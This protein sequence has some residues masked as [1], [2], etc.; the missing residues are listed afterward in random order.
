LNLEVGRSILLLKLRDNGRLEGIGLGGAGPA[1]LDLAVA[2]DEEL[3]K[4]PLHALEAQDAGLLL[5]EPVVEGRGVV[6]VDIDLAHDGEA[7]AIVDQA[8]VLD[9]VVGSGLL[10]AELVAREAKEYN[11]VVVLV[12]ELLVELL[13]SFVLRGETALGGGVDDEDDLALVVLEVNLLVA[14]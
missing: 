12:A 8:K 7:D 9:V 4:V 2:A 3:F 13:E 6:A 1:T 10:A 14:L 11:I 5:L